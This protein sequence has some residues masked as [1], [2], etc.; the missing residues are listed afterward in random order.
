MPLL[1]SRHVRKERHEHSQA[2]AMDI[3][4]VREYNGPLL[5][6]RRF[7]RLNRSLHLFE[8]EKHEGVG[9]ITIGVILDKELERLIFLAFAQ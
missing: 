5:C 6:L 4:P 7:L 9:G 2:Q 3:R 1:T 8:L